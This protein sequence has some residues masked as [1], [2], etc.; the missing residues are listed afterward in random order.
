ML[1]CIAVGLIWMTYSVRTG[2][3][4]DETLGGFPIP[5][6]ATLDV[7]TAQSKHFHWN[8]AT[9]TELPLRYRWAIKRAGFEEVPAD[10]QL[11]HFVKDD[12]SII[13]IPSTDYVEILVE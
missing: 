13:V 4:A 12:W 5:K 3:L 9:G 11:S 7:E 2:F 10:G 6:A 1:S 8:A